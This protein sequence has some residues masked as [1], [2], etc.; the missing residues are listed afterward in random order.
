[1][2]IKCKF[3]ILLTGQYDNGYLEWPDD[4][5]N[6]WPFLNCVLQVHY[7]EQHMYSIFTFK[8]SIPYFLNVKFSYLRLA[9]FLFYLCF[10]V[11]QAL[12]TSM[13]FC[14]CNEDSSQD[15]GPSWHH[16]HPLSPTTLSNVVE[17]LHGVLYWVGSRMKNRKEGSGEK[18]KTNN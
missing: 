6:A 1:M 18:W 17:S 16:L 7:A 5:K 10:H 13:D 14:C 3:K 8:Y 9:S 15:L 2:T 11:H 12:N 4:Y